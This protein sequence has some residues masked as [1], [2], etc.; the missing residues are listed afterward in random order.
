MEYAENGD[1]HRVMR[2]HRHN[3]MRFSE[4]ELWRWSF[5]ILMGL[6]YL[7][8][9]SIMHRD[10]KALNI[11][12]DRHNRIKIGDLGVSKILTE[13]QLQATKIGTPLYLSPEQINQTPYDFKI[14]IWGL[15]CCLFHLAALEP[16]FQGDNLISLGKAIVEETPKRL[17]FYS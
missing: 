13:D 6:A 17:E 12:L 4:L 2:K 3:G 7:H 14:D 9:M 10:I 11:F 5:E 15:G 1:L 16:P 8:R